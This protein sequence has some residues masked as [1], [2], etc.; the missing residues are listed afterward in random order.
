[1]SED[2]NRRDDTEDG[3]TADA[4]TTSDVTGGEPGRSE[5]GAGT[6][7]GAG[8]DTTLDDAEG[9][10]VVDHEGNTIGL[11]DEVEGETLY[12]QPDPGLTDRLSASLGWGDRDADDRPIE[13]DRIDEVTDDQVVLEHTGGV[14]TD[15]DPA[16][17]TD[18]SGTSGSGMSGR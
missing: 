15:D 6:S 8:A 18:V 11:V 17:D 5:R 12:V 1:M 2:P 13:T 9:K 3:S 7:P 14:D 4:D 10:T 16:A